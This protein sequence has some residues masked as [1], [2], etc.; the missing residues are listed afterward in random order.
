[1]E[2]M[3]WLNANQLAFAQ[4]RAAECQR[5]LEALRRGHTLEEGQGAARLRALQQGKRSGSLASAS[6][7]CNR[8][9]AE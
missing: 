9:R 5:E 7:Q 4:A 8:G 3:Q 1:M 2:I 6:L